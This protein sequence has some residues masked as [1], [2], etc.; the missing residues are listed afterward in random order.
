MDI[1]LEQAKEALSGRF[2]IRQVDADEV[3]QKGGKLMS[4]QDIRYLRE[5]K[6]ESHNFNL[7]TV[8]PEKGERLKKEFLEEKIKE[9][10][11]KKL[12][13]IQISDRDIY[14]DIMDAVKDN[15]LFV[16]HNQV[17]DIELVNYTYFFFN[18]KNKIIH[19]IIKY[20]DFFGTLFSLSRLI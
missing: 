14:S 15:D 12:M 19:E 9:A 18:E 7:L 1:K 16:S 11:I 10:R 17:V 3:K 20:Q 8:S 5:F 4:S 2:C 6:V 13:G